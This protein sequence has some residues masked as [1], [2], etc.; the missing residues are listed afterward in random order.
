MSEIEEQQWHG[1][2]LSPMPHCWQLALPFPSLYSPAWQIKHGPPSLP[3][4]PALHLQ[5][6]ATVEPACESELGVQ[7]R[8]KD[9]SEAPTNDE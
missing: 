6:V 8:Q 5:S 4:Y 1:G 9:D 7:G 3:E 2:I